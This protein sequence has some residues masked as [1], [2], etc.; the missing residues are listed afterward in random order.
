MR[1][2]NNVFCQFRG[3]HIVKSDSVYS[4][5]SEDIVCSICGMAYT[6]DDTGGQW[7]IQLK[8]GTTFIYGTES[9]KWK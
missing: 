5:Y 8:D 3:R 4:L 9:A 2:V 6:E 7:D 1:P